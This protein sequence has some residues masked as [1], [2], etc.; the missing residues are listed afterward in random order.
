ML[1]EIFKHSL[2]P[3][4][5]RLALAAVFIYHGLDKILGRGNDGGTNWATSKGTIPPEFAGK[6]DALASQ[7][8]R[9]A[10]EKH[11][12]EYTYGQLLLAYANT[13]GSKPTE[14]LYPAAQLA[15]ALGELIGG[16]ALLIGLLT[17]LAAAGLIVIQVGAILTVTWARGFSVVGGGYEY[18]VVLI[19]VCLALICLGSGPLSVSGMFKGRRRAAAARPQPAE[20][21]Q[22]VNA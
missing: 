1:A 8:G 16:V 2:A 22:P 18:N 20:P 21:P 14:L 7:E 17:R 5:L 4:I 12:I 13:T 9:S 6:L 11:H 10:E 3:L 19:A 15:V